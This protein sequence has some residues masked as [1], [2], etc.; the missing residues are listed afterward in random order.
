MKVL[1]FGGTS[2]G[3]AG[4]IRTVAEILQSQECQVTAVFSALAGTTDR[5]AMALLLA[6]DGNMEYHSVIREIE[7]HHLT[8]ATELLDK[9]RYYDFTRR[10]TGHISRID[11]V[12]D[13]ISRLGEATGRS[14]D[15]VSGFGELMSLD[16]LELF[17]EECGADVGRVD[18][19]EMIFTRPFNGSERIDYEVS[20]K[21][22]REKLSRNNKIVITSGF[23]S[24]SVKGYP[25]TL[26][27]GGS[28]HTAAIIAAAVGAELLEIWTDVSGIYT[29]NPAIAP[30]ACPIAGLTY[31]EALEISHF[32]ARVIY[33]PSIE[34]VMK[35]EI[36]VSI[37]NTFAPSEQGTL[38][39]SVTSSNGS[40]IKAVTSAGSV[41]LV[42]LAGS[43]M[44]GVVGIAARLFT[45]L[46]KNNINV[47]LIT[48][49]SSEQSICIAVDQKDGERACDA[50]NAGF[51]SEIEAG[52]V[53]PALR[54][55]GFAIVAMIGEGM[56][57]SVGIS[58]QAFAALGRNGINIHAIAQ[59]SSELNVSVV[60]KETDAPKAVNAIH[61][62]FFHSA[63]K[64]I[65][66]FL[67]G[68]GNVGSA[69][70]RQVMDRSA[71]FVGE[72]QTEFRITG[73]A[74]TR[75]MIIRKEG[76]AGPDW[77]SLMMASDQKSNLED[78]IGQMFSLNLPNTIFI[79]NTSSS[80]VSVIYE[81]ILEKSISIVTSNKLAASSSYENY[82]RLKRTAVSKRVQFRFGSN[83][84]AGLP[85][86]HTIQN[87]VKTGDKI[88][89]IDAVLSGSLNYI[90]NSYSNGMRFSEAVLLALENG[91]TEPDPL[92]DLRGVDIAR[93]LLILV[94]ESGFPLEA[95]DIEFED[96]LPGPVP[97][98]YD[99]A[100]FPSQMRDFDDFFERQRD[101]L[102]HRNEKIRIIAGY[103]SGR[104]SVR[105][106]RV[107]AEHPFYY[108][109]G[110][111]NIVSV[112]SERYARQPLIIKG[113]GAGADVTA[114]GIFADILS[115]VNN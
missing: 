68:T 55:D 1:K 49:A 111:D 47:I 56:K 61:Q 75:R 90:F 105:P 98:R 63:K 103:E 23:I 73:L 17:L 102:S 16:L 44:A 37:R 115:V 28:D 87:M 59:G 12:L 71:W 7:Q 109:E 29:A 13:S 101:D 22:I 40:A 86:I 34:P 20:E 14:T 100:A 97:E 35:R 46:A 99:S 66:I 95:S 112:Y 93:K 72:Y 92:T 18:A 82:S 107:S 70:V 32:G 88:L 81:R 51:E 62:E 9:D 74:N 77:K 2:V 10:I 27:R 83:V 60:V 24:T 21:A 108:L 106:V 64:V 69:L 50:I 89:R 19:R 48:Q 85:V 104:A 80:D 3:S 76:I 4:A 38:I 53:K 45:A 96:Y 33:P 65:N 8:V 6:S 58:G 31:A 43:G 78:F 15:L 84:G 41:C 52:R 39:S 67:V 54:E 26:G 94:R 42:S 91:Y 5:L 30:D 36:P 57:H 113:A 11:G 79:D 110:N 25:S 114:A